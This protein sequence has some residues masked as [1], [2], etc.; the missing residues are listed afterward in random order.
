[1]L[2]NKIVLVQ[3]TSAFASSH[4]R[5]AK[6]TLLNLKRLEHL[7]LKVL[8][9]EAQVKKSSFYAYLNLLGLDSYKDYKNIVISDYR[10]CLLKIQ[11]LKTSKT[12]KTS[13]K[14][15][16]FFLKKVCIIGYSCE[17]L[18]AMKY[19]PYL[20]VVGCDVDLPFYT[21]D[22]LKFINENEAYLENLLFI[23]LSTS[24]MEFSLQASR[25]YSN[26]NY[27]TFFEQQNLLYLGKSDYIAR[28]NVLSIHER[29]IADVFVQLIK[30]L[31][32]KS[33]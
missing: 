27:N 31:H 8:L 22:E 2:L 21:Q 15:K 17:Q 11:T 24:P 28:D 16:E 5:I 18:I 19:I 20:F 6:Y 25:I 3:S 12:I 32:Q 9:Q 23:S 1:M 10:D 29:E 26:L 4:Y 13:K 14:I 7:S 33:K 30:D